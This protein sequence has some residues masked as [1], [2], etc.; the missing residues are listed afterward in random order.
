MIAQH[1]GLTVKLWSRL[2]HML[3]RVRRGLTIGVRAVIRSKDGKFLLVRHTYTPGWHFP[4]G[5]IEP[6]ETADG[7]LVRELE[8]ETGIS[9]VGSPTLYGIYF[10]RSV[11]AHD[12]VLLYLCETG[13]DA[14]PRARS[15]EI[16]EASF[17]GVDQLPENIDEG[18]KRRIEEIAGDAQ[19]SQD[20]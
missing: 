2:L 20:W 5:G 15:L 18:T 1:Q 8:Q 9:I 16:A 4:G 11:G 13:G 7:A 19:V 17:F 14:C 10:N 3:F 6:N 12:H